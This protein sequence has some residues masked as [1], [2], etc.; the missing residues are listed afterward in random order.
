[1]TV[2]DNICWSN[3]V[4]NRVRIRQL[5]RFQKNYFEEKIFNKNKTKKT[6]KFPDFF[7]QSP[8]NLYNPFVPDN[9]L[10]RES[11]EKTCLYFC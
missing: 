3:K 2:Y 4:F 7:R 9:F 1:M 6:N 10:T 5:K 11:Q 8:K